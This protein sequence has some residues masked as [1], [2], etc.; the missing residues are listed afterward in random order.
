MHLVKK[1]FCKSGQ[2]G[3]NFNDY[4][5][6]NCTLNYMLFIIKEKDMLLTLVNK[7]L[8]GGAGVESGSFAGPA[9]GDCGGRAVSA[10]HRPAPLTASRSTAAAQ[11]ASRANAETFVLLARSS[12]SM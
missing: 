10:V 7:E 6:G 2:N 9:A 3:D 1:T 5:K 11:R 12:A 8:E 4:S